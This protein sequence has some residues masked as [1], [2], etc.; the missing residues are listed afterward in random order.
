[1]PSEMQEKHGRQAPRAT[2]SCS[3][4]CS[5]LSRQSHVP[6]STSRSTE[7]MTVR[8]GYIAK[9]N[10]SLSYSKIHVIWLFHRDRGVHSLDANRTIFL[11][12]RLFARAETRSTTGNP[13]KW[14]TRNVILHKAKTSSSWNGWWVYRVSLLV[15]GYSF[16]RNATR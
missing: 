2:R 1:M 6:F 16:S 13:L 3:L 7:I 14:E 12:D 9:D 4:P 15:R 11:L 10:A 8:S 5:S